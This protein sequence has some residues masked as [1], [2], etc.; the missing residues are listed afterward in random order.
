M[1][2]TP[3]QNKKI[4]RHLHPPAVANGWLARDQETDDETIRSVWLKLAAGELQAMRQPLSSENQEIVG[5]KNLEELRSKANFARITAGG[6]K[7]SHTHD[8]TITEEP[9][10]YQSV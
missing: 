1:P 8:I 10:S 4:L 2:A 7:E 5:A 9:V 6:L 3:R